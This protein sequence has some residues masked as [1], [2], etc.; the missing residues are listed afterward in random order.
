MITD[1]GILAG[2]DLR[3]SYNPSNSTDPS[4][5]WSGSEFGLSWTDNRD[6]NNE[7]YFTLIGLDR[8]GDGLDVMQETAAGTD[9]GD[10][11]TD[12]DG[13]SDGDEVNV[14]HTDPQVTDSDGDGVSD[15]VEINIYHTLP[16]AWDSDGDRLPDGFEVDNLTNSLGELDPMYAADG[17]MDFD[18]D[19]NTNA[20]EYWNGSD[21]WD[22]DPAPNPAYNPA[23]YYWGK[24]DNNY[25]VQPSDIVAA[26]YSYVGTAVDFSMTLPHCYDVL[27]INANGNPDPP[28]IAALQLMFVEANLPGG[29]PSSPS[30]LSLEDAPS[31]AVAAGDTTHVT[32]SVHAQGPGA[33]PFSSGFGV[34]FWVTS[35]NAALLGGEGTDPGEAPGNRYDVSMDAASGALANI[36]VLITGPGPV[37]VN[38]K[39]PACGVEP[40]GRWCGEVA[41]PAAV[42]INP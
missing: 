41:L 9:E 35:G 32:V 15:G 19:L 14:H 23:C 29:Y 1:R 40:V 30:A 16:N 33:A 11:D 38:A 10:W 25:Y 31:A 34:V 21:P 17:E 18:G 27:D 4:L 5:A 20:H 6:G 3:V 12:D 42:V 36:V 8:D 37:T 28:D 39:V 2:T 13:V 7:I 26:Q 22:L 24:A